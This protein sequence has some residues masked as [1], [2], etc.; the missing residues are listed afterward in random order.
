[1]T[2]HIMNLLDVT[3]LGGF[4]VT[5]HLASESITNCVTLMLLCHL[6]I[7]VTSLYQ[8][9]DDVTREFIV[10]TSQDC[11]IIEL[12]KLVTI[13]KRTGSFQQ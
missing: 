11:V 3:R 7:C 2:R 8:F 10:V 6:K 12:G 13:F 1:M 4:S 5:S 9:K